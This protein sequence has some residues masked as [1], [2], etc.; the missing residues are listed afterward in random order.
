[1]LKSALL[2]ILILGD[3]NF[4][5]TRYLSELEKNGFDT[6]FSFKAVDPAIQ[7]ADVAIANLE[8]PLT[9]AEWAPGTES[10]Q[11][12]FR[13]LPAF[14]DAIRK[15]GIGILL[16]GNNHIA[17]AGETGI[18]DTL[19]NLTEAGI[20]WPP[21]PV[22]G[23][24]SIESRHKGI[25]IWNADIF[26]KPAAHPWAVPGE[27]LVRLVKKYYSSHKAPFL[28]IAVLHDHFHGPATEAERRMLTQNLREAGIQWVVF[29]GEHKTSGIMAQKQGGMHPGLGD[30]IFGC[31][32][33][34]E[35]FG[36]ALALEISNES[37]NAHEIEVEAGF[38]GN[39]YRARF[40][41]SR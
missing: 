16:L 23:P 10:K 24:L 34:G 2:F 6:G 3:L 20:R 18:N 32:C 12:R 7:K 31:D 39:G 21:P 35:R 4:T 19:R 15:A 33:S 41:P 25:D 36:K 26:S 17:D 30:F 28:T 13:Q 40:I 9:F 27:E 1:M 29:G 5:G 38:S 22:D 8:G 37:T 14:A 11:W